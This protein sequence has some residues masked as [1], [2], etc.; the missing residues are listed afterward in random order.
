MTIGAQ[1][2]N[3]L[4]EF[5]FEIGSAL[6]NSQTLQKNVEGLSQAAN[7]ALGS[8]QTLGVGIAANLGLADTGLLGILG[9]ALSASEK[10]RDAQRSFANIISANMEHFKGSVDTFQERLDASEDTIRNIVAIGRQFAIP[11][12]DLLNLS[13]TLA[14][15]LAPSGLAG[16]HNFNVAT[17]LARSLLKAAPL[18]GV[19]PGMIQGEL[20][21]II[22]GAAHQQNTLFRRL[23]NET[24]AFAPFA[25]PNASAKFNVLPITERVELLRKGLNQ[26]SKDMEVLGDRF[27]SVT[28]QM[29]LLKDTFIGVGSI[30]KP[31]GDAIRIPIAKVLTN[32]NHMLLTDGR[33]IV[34]NISRLIKDVIKE[35]KN[36][37]VDLLQLRELGGDLHKAKSF[38]ELLISLTFLGTILG[39]LGVKGELLS[40][41]LTPVSTAFG[42]IARNIGVILPWI[43]RLAAFAL[44]LIGTALAAVLPPMLAFLAIMQVIS[45]AIAIAH[46]ND[47]AALPALINRFTELMLRLGTSFGIIISPLT[48]MFDFFARLLAPIFQVT[49]TGNILLDL[50]DGLAAVFEFVG[51]VVI[52]SMALISASFAALFSLVENFKAKILTGGLGSTVADAFFSEFDRF[53]AKNPIGQSEGNAVGANVTNIG[54]QNIAINNAFKEQQEPDRI[55]FTLKD[56][57][58]KLSQ[59]PRQGRGNSF[60]GAASTAPLTT[61]G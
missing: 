1:A 13:K 58:R 29:N 10:F 55:A 16:K 4:T 59:A 57:I 49:L 17:D 5:K 2:F 21:N 39:W 56:Q 33:Q 38:S 6:I 37:I 31:L 8:F 46:V 40:A 36:F 14:A 9:S 51:F 61:P 23:S 34:E 11:T 42:F 41:I 54:T 60:G 19:D 44:P 18:L 50:L 3:V 28:G 26:F 43:F 52:Q 7:E 27:N 53:V 22:G 48:S 12:S 20:A 15:Q 24:T 35:P 25:G 45:R 47:A 30:L 32:L